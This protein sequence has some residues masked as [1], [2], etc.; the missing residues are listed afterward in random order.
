LTEGCARKGSPHE[1]PRLDIGT[2]PT[3]PQQR[4]DEIKQLLAAAGLVPKDM[5][6]TQPP[7][8]SRK[9]DPIAYAAWQERERCRRPIAHR[10]TLYGLTA[11]DL[12]PHRP[13]AS[14]A[15]KD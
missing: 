6:L 14:N 3:E 4:I 1:P 7:A 13:A 15:R 10:L 8:R 12:A 5:F 2:A 9:D 11:H